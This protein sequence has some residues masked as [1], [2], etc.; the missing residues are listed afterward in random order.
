MGRNSFCINEMVSRALAR[1]IVHFGL[2]VAAESLEC[3]RGQNKLVHRRYLTSFINTSAP[4][5]RNLSRAFQRL[6]ISVSLSR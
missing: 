2:G 4:S 1:F 5:P 3:T 6:C